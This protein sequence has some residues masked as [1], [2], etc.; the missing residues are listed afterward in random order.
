LSAW[1]ATF[2]KSLN[3]SHTLVGENQTFRGKLRKL[4]YKFQIL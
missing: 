4:A 2:F 1:V 3:K